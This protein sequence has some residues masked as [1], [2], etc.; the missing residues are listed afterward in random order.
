MKIPPPIRLRAR[1][2]SAAFAAVFCSMALAQAQT[3]WRNVEIGGGGFVSGAVFHPTEPGLVYARTD[4]GGAYRMDASTGGR[5]KALLDEVGGLNN[6]SQHLGV[7]TIGVDPSDAERVY[8]FT[9]QF[10]GPDSWKLPSRVYRSTNR[11]DTWTYVTPGFKMMGNGEGRGTSERCAVNPTNGA[12]ILVG[13]SNDG[14]WRST[15]YGATWAKLPNFT[16]ATNLNYVIY[17]PAN[18]SGPGPARRV[19]A[20][21]NTLTAA[22]LWYSDDNGDT[23]IEVP[24]QPGRVAGQEMF[25]LMGSFDAAGV[26]YSVWGDQ[27]G[28]GGYQTRYRIAKLSANGATW[29]TITPSGTW[30]GGYTGISADPRVAGHV[31]LTTINRWQWPYDE[32]YRT[33]NGGSSWTGALRSTGTTISG[34][35][36]P[37]ASD[38]G[39]HWMT[40]VDI[41]PF[42]SDRVVFNTGFGLFQ[43]TNLSAANASRVWTFFNDGLEEL[44]GQNLLSPTGGAPL[45]ST[46][47]DFS[48]FRHDSIDRSPQRGT[49]SPMNGGNSM[50]A[51]ADLAPLRM[52]R[53]SS[54]DAYYSS[55]GGAAWTLFSSKPPATLNGDG[56]VI[57]SADGKRFLWCPT[58]AG[59]S[60]STNGSSW[61]A[62][63]NGGSTNTNGNLT[64]STLAGTLG[65]AGSAD[66]KAT[67]A[68]F[69]SPSAIAVGTTGNRYVADTGNHMIRLIGD[70]AAVTTIAGTA[71]APGTANGTGAAARFNAPAGIV[72]AS[73]AIFV[74]DTGNHMIRKTTPSGVVTTLA[75]TAGTPGA[76]NGTGTAALFNSPRGLGADSAGNIYVADTGNHVIRKVTQAGVVTTFAGTA[77]VSGSTDATG[78]AASFNGPRGV[79]VDSSG[80]VYV[81]DTGNHVI[82]M[83]TSAGVVST[84]AGT[85][86]S[87]GSANGTGAAARFNAPEGIARDSAGNL[88]VADTGNQI[89][90]Q[91]TPAGVVT[92]I[93]GTAGTVGTTNSTGAAAR[94]NTPAGIAAEPTGFNIYVGDAGNHAIRR[95]SAYLTVHPFADRVDPLRFYLWNSTNRTLLTS[96]DGG[97]SFTPSTTSVPTGMAWFRTVPGKN[98]HIWG[99][100]GTSGLYQSTDFGATFTKLANVPEI[101]QLDFGKAAPGANYPAIYIWGRVGG[102]LGFFRSDDA[103]ASWTRI[104]DDLHQFGYINDMVADSRTYGRV[105]LSTSGRGIIVG[106]SSTLAPP[107]SQAS[108]F[109]FDDALASGWTNASSANTSLTSTSPVYRGSRAISVA[110]GT[111]QSAAFTCAARS[112]AGFAA[113]SFWLKGGDVAPLQVGGSR[114]G[115]ALE[116]YPVSVR[117]TSDWQQ[118]LVPLSAVGLDAIDDL[119][120]LRIEGRTVGG[121]VPGAFSLDDVTLMG[122]DDYNAAIADVTITLG[123][124]TATYDGTPKPV[125]VTTQP[126]GRA[127]IVTYNGSATPPTNAGTYTV[128]AT[129]DSQTSNSTAIGTLV[130][131]KADATVSLSGL[132]ATADGTPKSVTATTTPANLTVNITYSGSATAPTLAGNYPVTATINDPNYQG[133]LSDILI[134]RQPALSATGLTGWAS[135]TASISIG[136]SSTSSPVLNSGNAAGGASGTT[137]QAFFS[138]IT[139]VNAGDKIAL[140]GNVTLSTA[141]VSNQVNWF[142]FGLFD[143]RGQAANIAT[144]WLG[145]AGMCTQ[146]WER[147]GPVTT[148]VFTS[149]TDA[150]QRLPDA[151]P[152]AVLANSP[153]GTPPLSFEST[154]TRTATGVVVNFL[155]KRTDTNVTLMSYSYT[156]TSPNNN[157]LLTG[158]NLAEGT[159]YNPTYTAAGF[160]FG[161]AYITSTSTAS[162]QF[163]NVQVAFTPSQTTNTQFISFPTPGNKT[164]ASAPFALAAVASSGLPVTYSVVS[165]PATLSGNMV[166]VT[167]VGSVTI[168]AS[169]AGNGSFLPAPDVERTFTVTKAA[170]TVTLGSLSATYNGSP[171][172][173]TAT[174]NPAGLTVN[175]TY[176]GSAT[177]PTNAGSYTVVGTI[178]SPTYQGSATGTLVISKASQTISFGGLTSTGFVATPFSPATASSGLPLSYAIVSGPAEIV[179]GLVSLTGIGTVTVRASQPGDANYLAASATDASFEVVRGNATVT[180]GDL[181]AMFDGQPKAATVTT[182]PSGLAVAVTYNGSSTPP[183]ARGT[184]AVNATVS[185]PNYQGSATGS[186]VISPR[187]VTAGLTGWASNKDTV[188]VGNSTTSSPVL[189][190]ANLAGGASFSTLHTFFSPIT[191]ANEG[192]KIVITGNATLSAA[193]VSGLQNWFRFGIFDNRGKAANVYTGWLG[194]FGTS[195]NTYERTTETTSIFVSTGGAIART[196]DPAS[197]PYGSSS[198][199]GTPTIAFEYGVTRL[200]NGVYVSLVLRRTDTD[201]TVMRHGYTDTSPNN[202]G[203]VTAESTTAQGYSPTYNAVGFAFDPQCITSSSTTSVAFAN[204]QLAYTAATDA[205]AQSISFPPLADRPFSTAAVALSANATSGLP[206]TFSVVS[207]P[208]TISGNNTLTLTGVGTVTVRAAQPGGFTTLPATPVEQTFEVTKG[209]AS[210]TLGSLDAIFDGSAKEATATT[211]PANLPVTITYDG[212]GNAPSAIGSYAVEAVIDDA[213]YEGAATG[214]L[215]IAAPRTSWINASPGAVLDWSAAGNWLA[216]QKPLGGRSEAVAFFAGQ[217]LA[218]GI[219]TAQQD[220]AAPLNIHVLELDGNGPA[221]GTATVRLT[222]QGFEFAANNQTAPSI[223]LN[224]GVGVLYE[225]AGDLPLNVPLDILGSGAGELLISANAGGTGEIALRGPVSLT[226]SGNNTYTGPTRVDAGTLRV[227]GS[228]DGTQFVSVSSGATLVNTGIIASPQ[229]LVSAGGTLSGAG[230][231]RGDVIVYGTVTVSG[232]G[233]WRVEGN[234]VNTGTIRL[235]GGARLEVAGTL[236]NHGVLDLITADQTFAGTIS[237]G[238]TVLDLSDIRVSPMIRAAGSAILLDLQTREGHRYQLQAST[239]LQTGSWTDVGDPK[240]G[241]GTVQTFNDPSGVTQP[242]QFYRVI[243]VP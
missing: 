1:S 192:D 196:P 6:E 216:G 236:T 189:N 179:G 220:I 40:D 191:L 224:A 142:R 3:N 42:N 234:V 53:Q 59:A 104:N 141:G 100:A 73:G 127:T 25:S 225:I 112:T 143:N 186:L 13:T 211:A 207:G 169:Q 128:V 132:S 146:M 71:G 98:G 41:D 54:T 65:T 174:T 219:I 29:T 206:V 12:I 187:V 182:S 11:G 133:S 5:W 123:D 80:N 113:V 105:Y 173:A 223:K 61:T 108:Q 31:V 180:L 16:A 202:N 9:G 109:L 110:S 150:K 101:Y 49:H 63:A 161:S 78:A 8:V 79:V 226:L 102:V 163:S 222:G 190:A 27:T 171:R 155:V 238:G 48:G 160:G 45:I 7:M 118:V 233:T 21:A 170:A 34:G 116:S 66:G 10:A 197:N 107:A 32:V 76:T 4:V 18:A 214:L 217:N 168:R 153:S 136:A 43:T 39:P 117:A 139:L 235:T 14:I 167:G 200:A 50:L 72:V 17:A 218:A 60:Y 81:A 199:S 64:V 231:I 242:R 176:N 46:V 166:T 183:S 157:G 181:S 82:R 229:I 228:L 33:T 85:A 114:G 201:A 23:W 120:G 93:A 172:S 151:S 237:G 77:G 194:Y 115:V 90:R 209:T 69:T 159:G 56:R 240:Y 129:L 119:T 195:M 210:V 152:A 20:A 138:P 126:P 241:N 124:L 213:T 205:T 125:S 26:F 68:S 36:S 92:T 70:A 52:V 51:G 37:W 87:S 44:V 83:I 147:T 140:T 97:V 57:L 35:N 243:I 58:S 230:T 193:G 22:S 215:V 74:A 177:A 84:L 106:D 88:Y 30:Q 137:L 121:V 24:G 62:S 103:G 158:E 184:Y 232:P 185:D 154:I 15:D 111:A 38:M 203:I 86:G 131:G 28:P 55:D 2:F 94:F 164:M 188:T 239:T 178:N 227:T 149:G 134:I 144:G 96:A 122:Q 204:V 47:S 130:I 19:Y 162:A 67:A 165:G 198:P 95:T 175:F 221:S 91:I 156:D 135:N 145:Y 99:R 75:G 212:S 208:A 89:I 148:G